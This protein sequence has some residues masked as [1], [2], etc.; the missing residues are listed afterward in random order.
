MKAKVEV[1]YT[2]LI[3]LS[4][5]IIIQILAA[6]AHSF[7]VETVLCTKRFLSNRNPFL[8]SMSV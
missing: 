2:G 7:N 1:P 6:N 5:F 4:S 8:H 3:A